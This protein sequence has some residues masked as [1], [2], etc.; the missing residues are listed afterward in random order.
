MDVVY[1]H[2]DVTIY[3]RRGGIALRY[4]PRGFFG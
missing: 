3:Q 4:F 2:G 1:Q